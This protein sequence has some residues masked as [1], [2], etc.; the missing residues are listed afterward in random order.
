M[1]RFR[2]A[3]KNAVV[4]GVGWAAVPAALFTL[5]RLVGVVPSSV[6]WYDGFGL[7]ARF[8]IVG[9]V[10][11]AAVSTVVG[12]AYRGRRLAE[13]NWLKFGLAG[14]AITAVFVPLFLQLMN[15]LSDGH[16]I[17]WNLVLDD[18]L[19]TGV[20]GAVAASGSM[21][22][23]QRTLASSPESEERDRVAN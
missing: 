8:G 15:L 3:L 11:G 12:V 1:R 10:A 20:L 5:L 7:A 2:A 9:F 17:A 6:P 16:L 22:I 14:G 21:K 23:A 18:S 13:I 4:W 19:W